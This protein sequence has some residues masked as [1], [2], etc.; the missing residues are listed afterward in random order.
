MSALV[1]FLLEANGWPLH[2]L[3]CGDE[4]RLNQALMSSW[5]ERDEWSVHPGP[6]SDQDIPETL[7]CMPYR[8]TC[9]PVSLNWRCK[10]GP[11]WSWKS[12]LFWTVIFVTSMEFYFPN[13][14]NRQNNLVKHFDYDWHHFCKSY[15]LIADLFENQAKKVKLVDK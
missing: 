4:P 8:W 3:I 15:S 13:V 11:H 1:Y 5:N 6:V 2:A 12:Q 10:P 9:I 14:R 7:S